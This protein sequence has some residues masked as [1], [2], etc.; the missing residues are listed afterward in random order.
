M[1][2]PDPTPHWRKIP[3]SKPVTGTSPWILAAPLLSTDPTTGPQESLS[4][5][6]SPPNLLV[7]HLGLLELSASPANVF[8]K[9]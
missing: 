4:H 2:I 1:V 8:S 3:S 7:C 9:S 6:S 5:S